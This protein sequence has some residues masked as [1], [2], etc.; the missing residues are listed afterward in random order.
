MSIR[1]SSITILTDTWRCRMSTGRGPG[2]LTQGARRAADLSARNGGEEFVVLLPETDRHGVL[3]R[4][5]QYAGRRRVRCGFR[6]DNQSLPRLSRSAPVR[7]R[8]FPPPQFTV[9]NCFRPR[10]TRC[11]TQEVRPQSSVYGRR[12][13]PAK[14]CVGRESNG[15]GFAEFCD[16]PHCRDSRY[17]C[18][19]CRFR[20]PDLVTRLLISGAAEFITISVNFGGRATAAGCRSGVPKDGRERSRR[21]SAI[22]AR[23]GA[24]RGDG[25]RR[26]LGDR[27]G[28]LL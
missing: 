16:V 2:F 13:G 27:I 19:P 25:D 7:L 8:F 1:S 6:M 18:Y 10:T 11:T 9:R 4:A 21:R 15:V 3:N 5:E 22:A 26:R 28:N 24:S 23:L 17:F 20:S 12:I 14:Y